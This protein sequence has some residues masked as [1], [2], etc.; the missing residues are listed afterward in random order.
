MFAVFF[1]SDN[2]TGNLE[3]SMAKKLK[4]W[5]KKNPNATIHHQSQ[6]QCSHAIPEGGALLC[7]SITLHYSNP[8]PDDTAQE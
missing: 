8:E 3:K 5:R 1:D 2:Y 6:S 4:A 7:L